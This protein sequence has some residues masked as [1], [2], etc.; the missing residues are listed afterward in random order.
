MAEGFAVMEANGEALDWLENAV[1]RGLLNYPLLAA[2]DPLLE[3]I[4]AEPRFRAL[5]PT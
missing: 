2:H 5:A 1:R 4:R 3:P